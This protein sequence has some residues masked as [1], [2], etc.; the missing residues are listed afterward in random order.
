MKGNITR[1]QAVKMM[2]RM[3]E[4]GPLHGIKIAIFPHMPI[5]HL[6]FEEVEEAASTHYYYI[7]S[8]HKEKPVH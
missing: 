4:R 3:F 8:D 6:A 2:N 5:E 7:D 1:A